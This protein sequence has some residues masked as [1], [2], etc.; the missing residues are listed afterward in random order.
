MNTNLNNEYKE[1]DIT[2]FSL[3]FFSLIK[4]FMNK[5][6]NVIKFILIIT[7]KKLHLFIIFLFLSI[8]A[9]YIIY[10]IIPENYYS[11]I[12]IKPNGFSVTDIKPNIN[13]LKNLCKTRNY[14]LLSNTLKINTN[15]STKIKDFTIYYFVDLDNDKI[16]DIY[17]NS[18][19]NVN[20][21]TKKMINQLLI[22]IF[23]SSIIDTENIIKIE[24]GIL[25]FLSKNEYLNNN[26]LSFIKGQEELL[27][28]IEI[29]IKKLDSLQK[30]EYFIEKNKPFLTS[31]SGLNILNQPPTQLYYK[32][33]LSLIE[34]KNS[35]QKTL[36]LAKEPITVVQNLTYPLKK[37]KN[38]LTYLIISSI[39]FLG[40][41]YFTFFSVNKKN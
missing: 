33:I 22:K 10:K 31:S 14:E 8:T 20:D 5:I 16:G 7:I 26:Y 28:Q 34:Q 3:K 13:Y 25:N 21:S 18:K 39:I 15:I 4:K 6:F 2:Q 30:V 19:K 17:T 1:V 23:Y 41:F 40:I 32:D 9:G 11:D 27:K 37:Q 12:I 24:N 29:E 35:I 38:L 36:N